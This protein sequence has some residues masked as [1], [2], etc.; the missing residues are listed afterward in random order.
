MNPIK[1][2]LLTLGT[3]IILTTLYVLNFVED[4]SEKPFEVAIY[5][6][7]LTPFICIIAFATSLFFYHSW[8]SNNR[9]GF[10]I[11]LSILVAW[12][13]FVILYTRLL[14]L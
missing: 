12:S 1:I 7:Y 8:I 14:F 5:S 3:W 6:F 11:T 9:V 4:V 13:L 10:A 2:T